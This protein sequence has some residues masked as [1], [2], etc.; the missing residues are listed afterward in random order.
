M[1]IP[2]IQCTKQQGFALTSLMVVIMIMSVLAIGAAK[3]L[4]TAVSESG[5][6]AT[7]KYLIAVR[8]ATLDALSRHQD[9]FNLV[10]I[11]AAPEGTYP[12]PPTW[13][14]F[15]EPT[16]TIS[17]ADLKESGFL[18]SDFPD[19]PPMGRSVHIKFSRDPGAC[20]GTACEIKAYVY[21]CWPITKAGSPR[22]SDI[23][24]CPPANAAEFDNGLLS[25]A[26]RA[27]DGFGGSN[28]INADKVHGALFN[29]QSADLD[30][31]GG[32]KGHLVVVASQ[33]TTMFN[34]FVRQGDTRNI[35]LN[36]RLA[37]NGQIETNT[38]LRMN[39]NYNVG[40]ICDEDGRYATSSR[41][42]LIMCKGGN[43]FELNTHV[44][45][46]ITTLSNGQTAPAPFCP[47]ANLQPF[48]VAT[49]VNTDVTVTGGDINVHGT[50][51]GT[52]SGNG[53]VN[54]QG[55]VTVNGAFS[56]NFKSL[57]SSSIRTGQSASVSNGGLVSITPNGPNA[58]A[59]VI[60]GCRTI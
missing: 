45:T 49:L 16:K 11:S 3:K 5:A 7:G 60:S 21:T 26:I 38:G 52:I 50:H 25:V 41:Q 28:G 8:G 4:A 40:D 34:Q 17:V 42:S 14:S 18:K 13:A 33:N 54:N 24:I 23:S 19:R 37:V 58:R 35:Y 20:P 6:E 10:D 30:I 48:Y 55:A 46:S 32:S 47:S 44:V 1:K 36:N 56:G 27:T 15:T 31:P 39:T 29:F 43:W 53:N 59:L 22:T 57:P 51:T 9:A 12:I 2:N